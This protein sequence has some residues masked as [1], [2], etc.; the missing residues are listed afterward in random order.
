[1]ISVAMVILLGVIMMVLGPVL[2]V[3]KHLVLIG[4][5]IGALG[6]L[7]LFRGLLTTS[8]WTIRAGDAGARTRSEVQDAK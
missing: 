8:D 5:I 6:V 7:V 1:M 3:T 4:T 2:L